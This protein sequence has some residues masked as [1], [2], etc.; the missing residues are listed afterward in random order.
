[1]RLEFDLDTVGELTAA[2]AQTLADDDV[3]ATN[4]LTEPERVLMRMN[5]SLMMSGR[6]CSIE[7]PRVS[8]TDITVC[9]APPHP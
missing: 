8:W 3:Q 6:S 4:I 2:S 7:L 9:C 5:G 1:M